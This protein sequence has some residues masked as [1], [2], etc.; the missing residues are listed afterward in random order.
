[1][2]VSKTR[3]KGDPL[4]NIS[5]EQWNFVR[6]AISQTWTEEEFFVSSK[7]KFEIDTSLN[8]KLDECERLWLNL[9]LH[10]KLSKHVTIC[11]I[12]KHP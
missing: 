4:I 3:L 11:G 6:M 10:V 7:Y 2:G 12:Y 9:T 1:M 8:R 5:L